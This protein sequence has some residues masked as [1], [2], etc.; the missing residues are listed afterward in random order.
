MLYLVVLFCFPVITEE[1]EAFLD[2]RLSGGVVL[3]PAGKQPQIFDKPSHHH[4]IS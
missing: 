1:A 2:T 3:N 4:A